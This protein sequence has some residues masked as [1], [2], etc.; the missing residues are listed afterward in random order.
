MEAL[1]KRKKEVYDQFVGQAATFAEAGITFAFTTM[2]TK[3]GDL[4]GNLGRMIKAGLS[5]DAALTA[6][7]TAPA[8]MFGMSSV[9]GS[10]EKGK[11]AN[12]VVSDKPYFE[13]KSNVRFVIAD[14]HVFDYEAPKKKAKAGNGAAGEDT[15]AKVDGEWS[16]NLDIPG[17]AIGGTLSISNSGG[18][19][20]GKMMYEGMGEVDMSNPELDG[21]TL[22][23]STGVEYG[24]QNLN[25]DYELNFSGDSF[26]GSVS[27]SGFGT[28]DVKGSKKP[29]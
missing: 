1:T 27:I 25:L 11:I 7:T 8:E 18:D 20:S 24:G 6:L 28:F 19:V 29:N 17:Q 4:R 2:D 16:Y 5:E 3:T 23:F 9:M 10:V 22:Y 12:L 26:E 13:E 21:Q 14:G 15:A